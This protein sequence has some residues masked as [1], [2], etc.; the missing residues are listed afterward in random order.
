MLCLHS[1][2]RGTY[3]AGSSE[4]QTNASSAVTEEGASGPDPWEQT[5]LGSPHDLEESATSLQE[6]QGGKKTC[7]PD[8]E[9]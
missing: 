9:I 3:T 7:L 4:A 1:T 6:V 2:E 5:I 8:P